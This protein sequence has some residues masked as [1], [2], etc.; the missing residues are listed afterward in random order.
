M[1]YIYTELEAA[2]K[3]R[4]DLESIIR[5]TENKLNDVNDKLN[6]DYG[7]DYEWLKLK[8][9]CVEKDDGE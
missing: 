1:F 6:R 8:D 3:N 9:T 4:D 5:D 7:K 2:R